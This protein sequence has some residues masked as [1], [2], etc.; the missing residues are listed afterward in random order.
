MADI[1][2][3]G[4]EVRSES[5]LRA[6]QNLDRFAGV[7]QRVEQRV[8]GFSTGMTSMQSSIN[9]LSNSV[10]SA[11]RVMSGFNSALQVLGIGVAAN[12]M[13]NYA[14][15]WTRMGNK[16]A[17]ASQ[18]SGIQ[19]RSLIE[20]R[21]GADNARSSLDEYVDLYVRIMRNSKG[22][23]KSEQEIADATNIVSKAFAVGGAA[24]SEQAAG[25]L[26]LGQALGSGVLQGDELRSIRE[27]APILAQAIAD[28]FGTTIAG[29][30]DLGAKG[31]L[32]SD[33]I[34]KAILNARQ[35]IEAQFNKTSPTIE[36]SLTLVKNAATQFI[37]TMDGVT[38]SS[39]VVS[40]SLKAIAENFEYVGNGMLLV[41]GVAATKIFAPMIA[42]LGAT[43]I[44]QVKLTVAVLEGNA[45]MLNSR[46]AAL[47]KA[48]AAKEAALAD[49]QATKAALELA[50]AEAVKTKAALEATVAE[51]DSIFANTPMGKAHF[52][53]ISSKHAL[54]VAD[55]AE[56][57]KA[58]ATATII[59]ANRTDIADKALKNASNTA[60]IFGGAMSIASKAMN[61]VGG[62]IGVAI[63]AVGTAMYYSAQKAEEAHEKSQKLQKVWDEMGYSAPLTAKNIDKISESIVRFSQG[64]QFRHIQDSNK[65]LDRLLQKRSDRK[66]SEDWPVVGTAL[67]GDELIAKINQAKKVTAITA[68]D[69]NA[70]KTLR[71]QVELVQKFPSLAGEAKQVLE[72]LLKTNV[73]SNVADVLRDTISSLNTIQSGINGLNFNGFNRGLEQADNEFQFTM[74]SWGKQLGE[75]KVNELNA[76]EEQM[77]TTGMSAEEFS[78]KARDIV[79]EQ[80][81]YYLLKS[82]DL[83]GKAFVNARQ[84]AEEA[85]KVINRIDQRR[86][87]VSVNLTGVG[88]IADIMKTA[89]NENALR[90]AN[91]EQLLADAKKTRKQQDIDDIKAKLNNGTTVKYDSAELTKKAKEIYKTRQDTKNAEKAAEQA[92]Q[93]Q[94]REANAYRD[95]IKSGQDRIG[96]LELEAQI[97]G[98]TGVA[99]DTLR[100]K[101]ELEQKATDK[102]RVITA[103]K[104][105]EIDKLVASYQK[106]AE[107]TA[108]AKIKADIMNERQTLGLSTVEQAVASRMQQAGLEYDSNQTLQAAIRYNEQV[109][110]GMG[111]TSSFL[112]T[113]TSAA[114]NGSSAIN[115]M[116]NAFKNLGNQL[117][118][119][120]TQQLVAKAF[121]PLLNGQPR[122]GLFSNIFGNF[123]GSGG[124][125]MFQAGVTQGFKSNSLANALATGANGFFAQG[126]AFSPTARLFAKG[127]TFTN[128]IIDSPTPFKFANG[129]GF[130][131]G[132]MGEAGPE[133]VMPLKRDVRGTLGIVVNG[134]GHGASQSQPQ[135]QKTVVVHVEPSQYFDVRVQEISG[136]VSQKNIRNYNENLPN[137]IGQALDVARSKN[138]T[139][140]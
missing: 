136:E 51:K 17:A 93:A 39:R 124:D 57:E 90:E 76:L 132:L 118:E 79:P 63:L 100:M 42:N 89:E 18:S 44:E 37:G 4:I 94:Q 19:A 14:D 110:I 116:G 95:L 66:A 48:N 11:S 55:L 82:I 24:A 114:L 85:E 49:Q 30:K 97:A 13:K 91:Y 12:E 27:N 16:I 72:E 41:G 58:Y 77:K 3:L 73:N 68:E 112:N 8:Q 40:G 84:Q 101:L 111:L 29:L 122:G 139:S 123:L 28:E 10:T 119:M 22:V 67:Q 138:R 25:V 120:A 9:R 71:E 107:A 52:Q 117:M 102:G 38:G 99:A 131:N 92:E 127:G 35:Q 135:E 23:A 130:G 108:E 6:A 80:G 50:R 133:A 134:W 78:K 129:D 98:K 87:E 61:F 83:I 81:Y 74:K 47:Q 34:L 5:L 54:A 96:Q 7:T 69:K 36:Q 32:T 43:A 137:T 113:A 86:I 106:A 75:D 33:R 20:L 21:K 128:S 140:W 70:L 121:S 59:A 1:A 103:Q 105:E 15:S 65:E 109:K 104:R 115:A 56:K 53:Q 2:T 64:D 62:P 31:E 45:V 125:K 126:G 60:K 88:M 46:T 26:Q